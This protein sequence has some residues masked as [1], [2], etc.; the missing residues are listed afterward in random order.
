MAQ[1]GFSN[2]EVHGMDNIFDSNATFSTAQN[3]LKRNFDAYSNGYQV[4]II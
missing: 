2:I 3:P 1:F 4:N